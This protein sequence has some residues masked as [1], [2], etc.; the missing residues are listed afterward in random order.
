MI[1]IV[2]LP[3]FMIILLW[4]FFFLPIKFKI[5]TFRTF[6]FQVGLQ[7]SVNAIYI[8]DLKINLYNNYSIY[9][10]Q[11]IFYINL[12][13]GLLKNKQ[14]LSVCQVEFWFSKLDCYNPTWKKECSR[15]QDLDFDWTRKESQNY[16]KKRQN[17][18]FFHL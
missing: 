15:S 11:H 16:H 5:L 17:N 13:V 6:L 8:D 9:H 1:I 4:T 12:I 10:E 2:I 7:Q 3:F 18:N 14:H